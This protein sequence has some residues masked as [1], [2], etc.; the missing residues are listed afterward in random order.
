MIPNVPNNV[1]T[2]SNPQVTEGIIAHHKFQERETD[3]QD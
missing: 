3:E 1:P 2:Q